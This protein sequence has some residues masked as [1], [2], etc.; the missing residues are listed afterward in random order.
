MAP[1]AKPDPDAFRA[2]MQQHAAAV[3]IVTALLDGRFHGVTAT[4]FASVS[5]D[6]PSVLV[7]INRNAGA[8]R[9]FSTAR[10]F[11]VNLLAADQTELAA[12]FSSSDETVRRRRFDDLP[13]GTL[14]T[15][16][17]TIKGAL[18]HIDC[19]L[20]S[21]MDCKTH[22]IFIG[23]AVGIETHAEA[24]APLLYM[25]RQYGSFAP[26]PAALAAAG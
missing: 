5:A 3:T 26:L 17:P 16:A 4:A 24:S 22:T 1:F 10:H 9:A 6:P 20:V 23:L 19:N 14:A 18:G 7:C 13:L 8:H 11:C 21:A 25:T 2:V 15:G 12:R